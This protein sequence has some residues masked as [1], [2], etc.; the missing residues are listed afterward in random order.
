MPPAFT[1][2]GIIGR[3]HSHHI[4][5]T[6][7]DLIVYLQK[8]GITT[9]IETK[10]AELI[11]DNDLPTLD[12]DELGKQSDLIIVVGG[13]GSLLNAGRLVAEHDTPVLGINRGQLGF[14]TDINPT[15]L[16]KIGDVLAG[17]YREERRF[18]LEARVKHSK[19]VVATDVS[20][21]DVVLLPGSIAHMIEFDIYIDDAFVCSHRADGLIVATPTGST[22][23]SLSGG[24]PILHPR[25]DALALVPM[26]PHTLSSRPLVVSSEAKIKIIIN[27]DNEATPCISCDGRERTEVAPGDRIIIERI[28][29]ELR[30]IH[31]LDYNYYE[32]LRTKLHWETRSC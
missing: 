3:R 4:S 32:T 24:G 2:V 8:Q 25:L 27:P 29:T 18:M 19:S 22:A 17:H 6:L 23:Y 11:S 14:L 16:V 26:F 7:N 5:N 20:L 15:E 30:L 1:S 9:A 10:T 28:P 21:N 12:A 31:P 13:D